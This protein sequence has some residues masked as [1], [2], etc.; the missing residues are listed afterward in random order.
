VTTTSVRRQQIVSS[1]RD[2]EYR[3]AF[4]SAQI[5]TGL[6]F[7]IRNTRQA[8]GWSQS[9]L[10]ER[11]GMT[12]EAVSRLESLS[13]GKFSL[14]TLRRLA[15]AFD[16]A[17]EV[18]FVPF[19]HLADRAA[20]VLPEDL[21][22]PDFEHDRRLVPSALYFRTTH[23]AEHV[24]PRLRKDQVSHIDLYLPASRTPVFPPEE[25]STETE[26]AYLAPV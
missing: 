25:Q 9:E 16:V 21:S 2:K 10:A 18:R 15:S 5:D 23:T 8:R 22:V 3:D 13:Y 6:P 7:Q 26:M 14:A 17:L 1:L 19:S 12:Q 4:V 11:T 24:P 20:N